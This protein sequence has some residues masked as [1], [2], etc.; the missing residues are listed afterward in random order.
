MASDSRRDCAGPFV[1]PPARLCQTN[2][3]FPVRG[4]AMLITALAPAPGLSSFQ[5]P[6]H[7]LLLPAFCFFNRSDSGLC[8]RRVRRDRS[9]RLFRREP[10][11]V[12]LCQLSGGD[13]LGPYGSDKTWP[14]A[15]AGC[16][17]HPPCHSWRHSARL[18]CQPGSPPAPRC[19]RR[20]LRPTP[21]GS[22]PPATGTRAPTIDRPG[23]AGGVPGS[24]HR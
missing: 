1:L 11:H 15:V 22:S 3:L 19:P 7:L 18:A 21:R 4:F 14:S 23:T 17:R 10:A 20:P 8:Y 13:I 9:H 24:P 12:P 2:F 5:R 6:H 16:G